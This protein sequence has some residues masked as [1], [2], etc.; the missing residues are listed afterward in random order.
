MHVRLLL[1]AAAMIC[2]LPVVARAQALRPVVG[3]DTVRVVG[4][5]DT[6]YS[7]AHAARLGLEHV[8]ASNALPM[9]LEIPEGTVVTLPTRRVLPACPPANGI[10]LN[11]PERGIYFFLGGRFVQFFP[12]AV[13]RLGFLT[14]RGSFRVI[15]KIKD[16]TWYPPAWA[17]ERAPVGPGDK[18]PLGDRWIGTS[19]TR[20][21]IHGTQSPYSIGMCISH[22]CIRMYPDHVR[23]LFDQVSL[24]MPVR[25]EY[26]T[27]KLGVDGRTGMVYLA[28][29]PDV[30]HLRDPYAEA[31]RKVREAGLLG[32]VSPRAVRERASAQFRAVALM[33]SDF[34]VRVDGQR[35][36]L[37]IDPLGRGR[38]LWLPAAFLGALGLRVDDGPRGVLVVARGDDEMRLSVRDGL[39]PLQV[40]EPLQ[41]E[42]VEGPDGPVQRVVVGPGDIVSTA[43]RWQGRL[44]VRA[45]DVLDFFEMRHEWRVA[46]RT[47]VVSM[48]NGA[49]GDSG[50]VPAPVP[51]GE[52]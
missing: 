44:Y 50:N 21:G 26:E 7:L 38:L 20:V 2:L 6:L 48:R 41:G 45:D 28:T 15:E 37:P 46:E 51:T 31:M 17:D 52:P 3:V 23:A 40:S 14:P 18:N 5:M 32:Q 36:S 24:G 9:R 34:I 27:A 19:A 4:P 8:V 30:Y 10:V 42:L 22:G 29:F 39:P 49:N 47:L 16:P 13:G 33:G 11:V 12:V 35:L 1:A 43:C 25:I